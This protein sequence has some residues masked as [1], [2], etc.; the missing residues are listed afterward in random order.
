MNVLAFQYELSPIAVLYKLQR[1]SFLW[2]LVKM[3]AIVGGIF[4]VAEII[5]S[6]VHRSVGVLLKQR[7]GKLS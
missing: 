6:I 1:D 3:A 7:M 4:T 2:F 5:D